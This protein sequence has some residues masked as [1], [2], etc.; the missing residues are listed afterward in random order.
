MAA[1]PG[2]SAVEQDRPAAPL[3]DRPIDGPPLRWR[4]RDQDRLGAFAAHTQDWMAVFFAEIGDVG[5][6]AI[7][8]RPARR[9]PRRNLTKSY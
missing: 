5:T 6:G 4:Q 3:A 7:N 8:P 2:A 9:R 1:H